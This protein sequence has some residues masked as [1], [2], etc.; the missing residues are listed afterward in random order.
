MVRR[1]RE[2]VSTID[3]ADIRRLPDR[4]GSAAR[5]GFVGSWL[6]LGTGILIQEFDTGRITPSRM[7][8]HRAS[9]PRAGPQSSLMLL[10][11]HS[12]R[13]PALLPTEN[14]RAREQL[15]LPQSVVAFDTTND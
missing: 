3:P 1:E 7:L 2:A 5:I 6:S 13:R 14:Q 15:R 8:T 9:T 10:A 4:S 11:A 12:V